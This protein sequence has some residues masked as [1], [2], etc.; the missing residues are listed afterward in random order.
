[1]SSVFLNA[2][3]FFFLINVRLHYIF[4]YYIY[5]YLLNMI[6]EFIVKNLITNNLI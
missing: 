2:F 5:F 6:M 4:K 1:M 3:F